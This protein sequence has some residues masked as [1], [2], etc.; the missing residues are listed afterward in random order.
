MM[1]SLKAP[2]P[3]LMPALV[4][5]G[6]IACGSD[7]ASPVVSDPPPSTFSLADPVG[8]T[9]GSV[10]PQW[11]VT[12]LTVTRTTDG[13]IVRLD[14]AS[15]IAPPVRGDSSGLI[16]LV[17]LDLDQNAATGHA[18]V[19]DVVRADHG[20][21]GLGVDASLVFGPFF[22]DSTIVRDANDVAVGRAET[23]FAGHRVTIKVPRAML[24]NDDGWVNAAAVVGHSHSATDFAPEAGHLTVGR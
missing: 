19:V 11:D 15:D 24:G 20:S 9:F 18:A 7:S 14:F 1:R 16:G 21:T 10:D 4:L 12:A 5:A 2:L 22:G 13:V 6:V 3:M 17:E 23:S 8:D